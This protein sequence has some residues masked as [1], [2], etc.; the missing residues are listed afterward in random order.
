[1]FL[2][3]VVRV[4]DKLNDDANLN[5]VNHDVKTI[6]VRQ[7]FTNDQIFSARQHMLE[8]C[9]VEMA[10]RNDVVIATALEAMSHALA[11]QPNSDKNAGSRSLE[12]FHM[13]NL[14]VFKGKHDLDGALK[15]LKEIARIFRVMDY[16]PAQKV[17]YG[18][19]MLVVETDDWWSETRKEITW[20]MFCREFLR[21]YYSEYVRGT[22]FSKCI[23]F[24]NKFGSEINNVVGYHK[25]RVFPDLVD[26]CRIYEESHNA[27]YKLVKDRR[28]KQ[29]RST[30]YDAPVGKGKA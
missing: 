12:T 18:T 2:K 1:M 25:I 29:N 14:T 3:V 4:S 10:S 8:W 26:S 17:R 21:K 30:L 6:D 23:K 22:E 7:Q 20:A 24:E 9:L 28:G 11:N 27:H 19:H 16:T 13:E 5:E 15:W